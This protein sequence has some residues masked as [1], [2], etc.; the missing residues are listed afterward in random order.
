MEQD[1]DKFTIPITVKVEAD[2]GNAHK[3][4]INNINDAEVDARIGI[5][6]SYFK[7]KIDELKKSLAKKSI[8]DLR[9]D[10]NAKSTNINLTKRNLI[11]EKESIKQAYAFKKKTLEDEIKQLLNNSNTPESKSRIKEL[12]DSLSRLG[13]KEKSKLREA[14][15]RGKTQISKIKVDRDIES[16][17]LKERLAQENEQIRAQKQAR[18]YKEKEEARIR[19]EDEKRIKKTFQETSRLMKT[20]L[21]YE[22]ARAE[23]EK[24]ARQTESEYYKKRLAQLKT[25]GIATSEFSKAI[26]AIKKN[27]TFLTQTMAN[28]TGNL[29]SG[30][31]SFITG[32]V[33]DGF[34]ATKSRDMSKAHAHIKRGGRSFDK[35]RELYKANPNSIPKLTKGESINYE[36]IKQM[37]QKGIDFNLE[38]EIIAGSLN[39]ENMYALRG[40]NT[41]N[42]TRKGI[43]LALSLVQTQY[44]SISEAFDIVESLGKGD[45]SGLYGIARKLG[46]QGGRFTELGKQDRERKYATNQAGTKLIEEDLTHVIQLLNN[47]ITNT[48]GVKEKINLH[49]S[50]AKAS[51]IVAETQA[52]TSDTIAYKTGATIDSASNWY[53]NNQIQAEKQK[54][55]IS[56]MQYRKKELKRLKHI[57]NKPKFIGSYSTM[58]EYT[59]DY[60]N[61]K[62]EKKGNNYYVLKKQLKGYM[63]GF[64]EETRELS[65]EEVEKYLK[66]KKDDEMIKSQWKQA[67]DRGQSPEDI[68]ERGIS[69][70]KGNGLDISHINTE[71]INKSLASTAVAMSNFTNALSNATQQINIRF[72]DKA[73]LKDTL[74]RT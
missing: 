42:A 66:F 22:Q 27:T 55:N 49:K 73:T 53:T 62:V 59:P 74:G 47:K 45:I 36:I 44:A 15:E 38:S 2:T 32:G 16:Q 40:G 5:D 51:N 26:A 4:I 39:L 50:I 23:G 33:K 71:G 10:I 3:Q 37:N 7:N 12:K 30:L 6:T 54:E 14:D 11:Q 1:T 69:N 28:I 20:G 43:E 72:R 65:K 9:V 70:K 17:F 19:R 68:L 64:K 29:I 35:L 41:T 60:I 52:N 58:Q 46:A 67:R 13:I 24:R 21:S 31:A 57:Y 25:N 48:E 61:N 56:L 18:R 63:G 34:G 8:K